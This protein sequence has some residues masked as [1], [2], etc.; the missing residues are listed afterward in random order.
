MTVTY[1]VSR[2]TVITVLV[3]PDTPG[4]VRGLLLEGHHQREGLVVET[5]KSRTCNSHTL[6]WSGPMTGYEVGQVMNKYSAG[7]YFVF[8][9]DLKGKKKLKV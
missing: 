9:I 5:C 1:L 6:C 7:L 3:L 4:D 2:P 8:V